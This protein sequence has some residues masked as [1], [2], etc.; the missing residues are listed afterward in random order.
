MF[1][2]YLIE[3]DSYDIVL[4]WTEYGSNST[5]VEIE[6]RTLVATFSSNEKAETYAMKYFHWKRY[7]VEEILHDPE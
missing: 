3:F 1:Y 7:L 6:K 2:L 4:N 5:Y